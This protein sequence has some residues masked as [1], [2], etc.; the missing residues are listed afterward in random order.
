MPKFLVDECTGF[1]VVRFRRAQGFNTFSIVESMPQ[2]SDSDILHRAMQQQRVIVTND[3]DFGDMVYRDR[4]EHAG[5]VLL[6]LAD[7]S[8]ATKFGSWQRYSRSMST[9]LRIT[10]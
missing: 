9:N 8:T 5:I 10:S 4:R 6:R 7:D 2:A 3:K 1:A